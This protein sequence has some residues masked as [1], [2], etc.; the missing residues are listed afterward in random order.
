M[1]F[2]TA[3]SPGEESSPESTLKRRIERQAREVVGSRG[4]SVEVEVEGKRAIVR[5][6]GVKLFQKRGVRKQLEGIPALSGLRSTI[7]VDD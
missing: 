2:T 4:R 1:R 5:V 3:G 6:G 7:V